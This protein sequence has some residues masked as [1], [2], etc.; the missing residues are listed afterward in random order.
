MSKF[1]L[2]AFILPLRPYHWLV[3]QV[4]VWRSLRQVL[5]ASLEMASLLCYLRVHLTCEN[6][7]HIVQ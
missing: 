7:L 5:T 6:I 3:L 1:I 2:I 4:G